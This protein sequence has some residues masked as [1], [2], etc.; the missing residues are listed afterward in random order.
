MRFIRLWVF[1]S[2]VRLGAFLEGDEWFRVFWLGEDAFWW[3]GRVEEGG[4]LQ[5]IVTRP[6]PSGWRTAWSVR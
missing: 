5:R 2:R 3:F 1:C 6:L 4:R